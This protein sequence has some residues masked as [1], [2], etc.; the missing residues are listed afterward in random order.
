M[1]L[2]IIG[3]GYWG[4]IIYKNLQN[5]YPYYEISIFDPNI[6]L[7]KNTNIN[8]SDKAFVCTPA[9]T[10]FDIVKSL[11][12]QKIDVFCEKPLST[13]LSDINFMYDLAKL[14]QTKLF[15]DWT[16][17]FNETI[18]TIKNLYHNNFFGEIRSIQMNRLNMGPQRSDVNARWDLSSHDV[19][20]IQYL[21]NQNIQ[22]KQWIDKKRNKHGDQFDTSIGLLQYSTFDAILYSSWQYL[23]KDR[24]CIFEFDNGILVWD[25][26]D[27]SL[28]F[29]N[30]NL[31]IDT[32]GP[33]LQNSIKSFIDNTYDD[34]VQLT[35][36]IT[37]ILENN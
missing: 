9:K 13:N 28:K 22:D 20:I 25:D 19:S 37:A 14:N 36:D 5:L 32:N 26:I 10:H 6:D 7:Y 15:V 4:K 34:Q 3:Y 2:S 8:D 35:K 21:F 1:K 11:L 29:N 18:H 24:K 16:F 27:N 30:K 17:T 23:N 31:A 33:P 12:V